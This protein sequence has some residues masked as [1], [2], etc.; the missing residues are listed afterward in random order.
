MNDLQRL[1]ASDGV[2][3]VDPGALDHEDLL[4][5]LAQLTGSSAIAD[6]FCWL[7]QAIEI[8]Y[9]QDALMVL[10]DQS[11]D[12]LLLAELIDCLEQIEN[13]PQL[14]SRK[15]WSRFRPVIAS[16]SEHDASSGVAWSS[17]GGAV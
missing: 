11:K 15:A 16:T 17:C 5:A 7:C 12:A 3:P 1:L 13:I 6:A 8:A 9:V 4:E 10:L 2:A 14:F